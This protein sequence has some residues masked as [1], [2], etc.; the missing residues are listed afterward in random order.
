MERARRGLNFAQTMANAGAEY[1]ARNPAAGDMLAT[2][3][4]VG[5][6][7]VI[8]EYLH[9]HWAPMYFARVAWELS[10][11]DLHFAGVLPLH[12]N[13]RDTAVPEACEAAFAGDTNR[14]A[15]ESLKDFALNEF[16]RRDVYVKGRGSRA[17]TALDELLD[18]TPW[19]TMARTL[20]ES[21]EVAL[22]HRV[23]SLKAP[24]FEPLFAALGEGAATIEQLR[25][26]RPELAGWPP[27]QL[28]AALQ[29]LVLAELVIPMQAATRAP[30]FDPERLFVI[31]L[32]Y[33]QMMLRRISSELPLVLV[34]EAA[35]TGLRSS[36]LEGLALRALTE[37]RGPER[38]GWVHDFVEKHEL[39]LAIDGRLVADRAEQKV[40]IQGA[41]DTLVTGRL[42]KLVELGIILPAP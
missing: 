28:R 13:F 21:R 33:N 5:L 25:A 26:S 10:E 32:P 7:Y 18:T 2:M 15:F 38:P 39:R 1:F 12:L 8:H 42:A 29:R 35:G 23:V 4:R 9:E 30:A 36:A 40:V 14:L 27:D 19:G 11:N 34:S 6:P 31:P 20:P 16:F 3:S 22:P 17:S 24:M 37:V 41:I